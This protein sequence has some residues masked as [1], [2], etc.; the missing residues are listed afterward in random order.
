VG[1][2]S[3]RDR[4]S[5]YVPQFPDRYPAR[6][7]ARSHLATFVLFMSLAILWTLP[8]IAQLNTAIPG[9]VLGDGPIF[10]WNNWWVREALT[11]PP[12]SLFWTPYLF[13]PLGTDL[14]L[15]T[16]T[17]FPSLLAATVFGWLPLIPATNLVILLG[18]ALNGFC[19]YLLADSITRRWWPAL[20]AGIAYGGSPF[21]MGHL[22]GHYNLV[23]A[24]G[25]P[26]CLLCIR[27]GRAGSKAAWA[28]AGLTWLA[29][30]YTDYYYG[31]YLTLIVLGWAGATVLEWRWSAEANPR[32][33]RWMTTG[34]V[35][36]ATGGALVAVFIAATGG[37]VFTIA[38]R[39]VSI[40]RPTNLVT[41]VWLLLVLRAALA[42]VSRLRVRVTLDAIKSRSIAW[43]ILPVVGLLPLIVA[44]YDTWVAGN[45][46]SQSYRWRS[47]PAGIDLAS[48]VTGNPW[49]PLIGSQIRE[50]YARFGINALE[51]AAWIGI[52]LALVLWLAPAW[53]RCRTGKQWLL[54]GIA[55]LTW[56]LGPWLT[57]AGVQTGILL[58]ATLVRWVP[59]VGN[60]RMPGRAV[61][62]VYLAVS[63]LVAIGLARRKRSVHPAVAA[64]VTCLVVLDYAG[65]PMQVERVQV[66]G[67]YQDLRGTTGNLIEL[68]MGVRDGFGQTGRFDPRVLLHQTV[69]ERP[70]VGGFVGRLS[71][72]I[73]DAY[74]RN[75]VVRSL[76]AL[77]EDRTIPAG[78]LQADRAVARLA[79]SE[80]GVTAVVLDT[81]AASPPLVRYLRDVLPVK[82]VATDGTHE[83]YLVVP[84]SGSRR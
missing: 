29:T 4:S 7:A 69:H 9:S 49:N 26:L 20:L 35:V 75:P 11:P 40:T 60:A 76:L 38:G 5:S 72:R 65:F 13:A 16:H 17:L 37:G 43:L 53:W 73:A 19:A 44:A 63:M 36:A 25:L 68:P 27:H 82:K 14:T 61:I 31:I 45:Y 8:L 56:A 33:P 3:R 1:G 10:V 41:I 28:G 12:R 79:L 52:P 80:F 78:D 55:F 67:L 2:E 34:L 21:V 6:A 62:V 54:C 15:H 42:A 59:L 48:L 46:V 58:P 83:L 57:I 39:L 32:L 81:S 23:H 30:V 24:W 77:S 66:P 74:A 70:L 47:A 18:V 84:S 22:L 71:P 51:T 64:A 50:L